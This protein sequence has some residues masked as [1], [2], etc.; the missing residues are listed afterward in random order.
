MPGYSANKRKKR[1]S[2]VF[3]CGFY[4]IGFLITPKPDIRSST[5]QLTLVVSSYLFVGFKLL[6]W[7]Q[8]RQ[9]QT[10]VT[11]VCYG[12]FVCFGFCS[13]CLVL[14]LSGIYLVLVLLCY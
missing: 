2:K 13:I 3:L 9:Q 1:S 5:T 6:T 4:R 7:L 10:F 11:F 8:G 12:M 14:V